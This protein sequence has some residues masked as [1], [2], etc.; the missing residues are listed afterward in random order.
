MKNYTLYI[1]LF[2][3]LFSSYAQQKQQKNVK[4][5]LVLSGGGAKGLAHIG[6][7]KAI[8]EAGVRIDYIAG[9]SMG[10]IV[11]ALYASGYTADEL[12]Q[13]FK[14]VNF[15]E[16]IRDDFKRK[17]K[18][19]FEREDGDRHAVTL[20]FNKFKLGF[21]SALSKGQST[22]NF[23]SKKLYHVKNISNFSKLPIPFFCIATNIET[24]KQEILDHGYLPNAITASSTI[25][26]L[27]EPVHI[28]D[29]LLIDGGISNNYPID[30]LLQK[31]VD[32][33]IGVDVQDSLQQKENLKSVMQIMTQISN[34]T[35]Q[36]Q[37]DDKV[38]KTA[39]YIKPNINKY[40]IISF[41][42]G[43]EIYQEGYQA[44]TQVE[45]QLLA[46]SN[47]QQNIKTDHIDKRPPTAYHIHNITISGN[48]NY[49]RSYILGKLKLKTNKTVPYQKI[50]DGIIALAATDNFKKID[51][52][53]KDN[54]VLQLNLVETKNKTALKLG[55][56]YDNLYKGNALINL[57][58][59]QLLTNND[60][61]SLDL[62]LGEKVRY[63]FEYYLDKGY[64]WS[65]G[66]KSNL[67][68]FET[69]V[70]L[71]IF[72]NNYL[73]SEKIDLNALSLTN[74][75]YIE[76]PLRQDFSL[77]LGVEHQKIKLFYKKNGSRLE[78]ENNDFYSV[79]G[80]LKYD[81]FDDI[82]YPKKGFF[83]AGDTHFYISP[84]KLKESFEQFVIGQ[85]KMGYATSLTKKTYFNAFVEGGFRL[86]NN[87]SS[88][89]DFVLGGYGNNFMNNYKPFY[90]YNFLSLAGDGYVKANFDVHYEF[91]K[92]HFFTASANFANI[93]D[94]LYK[95]QDWLSLPD[96][97]GY[98][99]GYGIQTFLGP[100]QI[101][102]S[103]SPKVK[104][105]EWFISLGYW[106]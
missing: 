81:T 9:T 103:W 49:T 98:A 76:T 35:P 78:L 74:Q 69:E 21:P 17:N 47:R 106:F 93:D 28:D 102:S 45:A 77:A 90:G 59:K 101:K 30:E 5:G 84:S 73:L 10:A 63:N 8:E 16:I 11:G 86:G 65:I 100:M 40:S 44:A 60:I 43:E 97:Y 12:M 79:Y 23:Y 70:N 55:L 54:G 72:D 6:A 91:T 52:Q 83:V 25:P 24:G 36:S 18:S 27:F 96:Y 38:A 13:M 64:Y 89:H 99:L 88:T 26:S 39:I 61:V 46:L 82:F 34:F 51:Y 66:V 4:V 7:L 71:K 57:T 31:N 29:K 32:V 105:V 14:D 75:F 92:N 85:L 68:A 80:K 22:Y 3:A 94:G 95:D 48:E 41:D 62:I 37:M 56:H 42:K 58:H 53:L 2:L 67:N 1:F 87:T 15:E 33:V 20:P 19:F 50:E 104:K